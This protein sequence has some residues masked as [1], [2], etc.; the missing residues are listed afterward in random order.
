MFGFF[1]VIQDILSN[2]RTFG[3]RDVIDIAVVS[4]AMYQILLFARKSRA[5]QLVRGLLLLLVF[6]ALADVMQ[7]RT[8]RWVLTNVMQIGFIAAIVLFQPELRRTLEHMGQSTNWTILLFTTHRQ[9]P[10]LR[11]AWQSAVV[12]ICDAA[13]QLSDTRTGALMVLERMNNLDEIIRTGTP[14]SA[15]VI[16]EMLGTIFYEGT[17][18][19]DGAV[20]I[21]DMGTR[22]RAGLGM[23]ENSDAIVVVVSEETGIISLAKNGVL[24]RRLD[25]Q[26]LFNLLQEEIIPPETAEAQKQPLLNRLLNKGGAGKHAKTNAAR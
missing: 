20:V 24:I 3:L 5:G 14:L 7:L 21:R 22:H 12:A 25:R 19:H 11:G 13:E 2:L 9:D 16:P 15:D 10:T 26:N 1:D 17:P 23:S 8:V 4:L 6:Y 18:L